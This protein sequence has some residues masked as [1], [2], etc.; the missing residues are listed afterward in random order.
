MKTGL[1]LL[2]A[3][4]KFLSL[5]KR[6][7]HRKPSG[8]LWARFKGIL[9]H[10]EDFTPTSEA[11]LQAVLLLYNSMRLKELLSTLNGKPI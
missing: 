3:K 7:R 8:S 11:I 4:Q 9:I 6:D 2:R 5:A 1:Y 10:R